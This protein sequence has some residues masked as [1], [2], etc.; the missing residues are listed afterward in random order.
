MKTNNIILIIISTLTIFVSCKREK[1][2][3]I[4]IAVLQ[5]ASLSLRWSDMTILENILISYT[6]I[7][8]PFYEDNYI[9]GS[10]MIESYIE[11]IDAI[12]L[13]L[14]SDELTE[15]ADIEKLRK[16]K[17]NILLYMKEHAIFDTKN[18]IEW[19]YEVLLVA[20]QNQIFK[21]PDI[22]INMPKKD[23]IEA[24]ELEKL[25]INCLLHCYSSAWYPDAPKYYNPKIN[26]GRL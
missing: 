25:N 15:D 22:D 20:P 12:V 17:K 16:K 2:V 4:D 26:D 23:L 13:K 9:K 8:A 7:Y 24:L 21:F 11:N 6:E 1:E 5:N 18:R 19:L 14:E 10:C 3:E